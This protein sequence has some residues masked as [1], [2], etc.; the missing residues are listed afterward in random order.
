Y[1]DMITEALVNLQDAKGSSRQSLKKYL[2][3]N[4]DLPKNQSTYRAFN[5]AINAGIDDNYFSERKH[6]GPIKL[7]IQKIIKSV[8]PKKNLNNKVT[9]TPKKAAKVKVD[10]K[11]KLLEI[12]K[13]QKNEEKENKRSE[14]KFQTSK[15]L[16]IASPVKKI[17]VTN[18]TSGKKKKVNN[19][20][21]KKTK[22][23]PKKDNTQLKKVL[24]PIKPNNRRT[25]LHER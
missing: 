6:L 7:K 14:R 2:E 3:V 10:K 9:T 8:S 20:L 4:F 15:N 12:Q 19:T 16:N 23:P 13:K 5:A 21:P 1:R 17:P 24:S 22:S 18:E 25:D 11:R